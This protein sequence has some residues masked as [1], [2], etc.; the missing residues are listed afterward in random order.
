MEVDDPRQGQ[1][2][3]Q[4]LGGIKTKK[5][6][7]TTTTTTQHIRSHSSHPQQEA[8]LYVPK[9]SLNPSTSLPL[10]AC[11]LMPQPKCSEVTRNTPRP[12][13]IETYALD[14]QEVL[15]MEDLLNVLMGHEGVYIN[16]SDSYNPR[17]ELDR[18]KGPDYRTARGLDPSFKDFTRACIKIAST[19]VSLSAFVDKM[20]RDRRGLVNGALAAS[21]R[22]L[23]K[24]YVK[25]A[26]G[27]E[28]SLRFES[29]L[30]LHKFHLK[31]MTIGGILNETHELAKDILREDEVRF[32]N[33]TLEPSNDLD[34][35][36]AKFRENSVEIDTR[37]YGISLNGSSMCRGGI[38]LKV[39]AERLNAHSGD[40][41]A[42]QLLTRLLNDA[43][44]PYLQ[45]LSRWIYQGVI[46]DPYGEFCIQ[47]NGDLAT[48]NEG[49]YDEYWEQRY[50]VRKD[51]L[52]LLLSQSNLLE[53]VLLAGKYLN[54]VRECGGGDTS[55]DA[56][57]NWESIQDPALV[58]SIAS[59]SDES[60]RAL[61]SLLLSS[62]NLFD[63]LASLK[64]YFFLDRADYYINFQDIAWTELARPA[65]Q[66]SVTKLQ[67]LLD[68]C[69]RQPGSI[70]STDQY[71][72]DVVAS[73]APTTVWD[74]LLQIVCATD[75]NESGW[76][77]D[78]R[79]MSMDDMPVSCAFQLDFK[80]PFPLSLVISRR[81]LIRYQILFRHLA[82]LKNLER[83]LSIVWL[84]MAKSRHWRYPTS[85]ERL[86]KWKAFSNILRIKMV[87]FV[88]QLLYHCTAE[89]IEPNWKRLQEKFKSASNVDELIADHI[90]FLDTCLKECMLTN[91][92]LIRVQQKIFGYIRFFVNTIQARSHFLEIVDPSHL[93][94]F[95][96]SRLQ[97]VY[98]RNGATIPN[99]TLV[100]RMNRLVKTTDTNFSH[101]CK[102][103]KDALEFF[104][105]TE[106][107]SL[108]ALSA[109]LS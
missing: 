5:S 20:T 11:R 67:Y 101:S 77:S 10:L 33:A 78:S 70:T 41:T 54:I 55:K 65:S 49:A 19:Y 52:P 22:K 17:L 37:G 38:T 23:L 73:L 47:E 42:N 87:E 108:L 31:L 71:K 29:G 89:V 104:A 28:Y 57:V 4:G 18:L 59:A 102:V 30:T 24:E 98:D 105:A 60:N 109:R 86:H 68:L 103:F 69:L 35:L 34:A 97:P 43:S 39:I 48:G 81:A 8:P 99:D 21:I 64:H 100:E 27:L 76:E 6:T 46:L 84:E 75:P 16:Y 90:T 36:L 7:I 13:N 88:K 56:A 63:R 62:H 12:R 32:H 107:T 9:V 14:V 72:D 61:L 25:L 26:Q 83:L 51:E 91:E 79:K 45:M 58:P 40:P 15:V 66:S 53:K 80:V 2:H 93:S 94:D 74:Y 3:D 95:E 106:S 50:S 1:G 92:K 85:D 82:E 44:K 96:R